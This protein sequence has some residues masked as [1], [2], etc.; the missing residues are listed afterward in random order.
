MK[1]S[2]WAIA[3]AALA[4]TLGGCTTPAPAPTAEALTCE[5]IK[6]KIEPAQAELNRLAGTPGEAEAKTKLEALNKRLEEQCREG[7]ESTPTATPSPSASATP[8]PTAT[9][10]ASPTATPN[11]SATPS[12]AAS[13]SATPTATPIQVREYL[14]WDQ[15]VAQ[16]PA[17]LREAIDINSKSTGF[18]WSDVES[19]SSQRTPSGKPWDARVVLIFG[20]DDTTPA[21]ARAAAGTKAEVPVVRIAAC[22]SVI[23]AGCPESGARVILA[24]I[25]ANGEPILGS[26]LTFQGEG[27]SLLAGLTGKQIK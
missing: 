9:W 13:P 16:P 26:G 12:A 15:V 6:A 23:G 17:G 21:A 5:Q 27:F 2:F 24:P 10:T 22:T 4:L 14:G 7:E 25:N 8:T 11:A 3:L 20:E 1:R 18:G 19:W